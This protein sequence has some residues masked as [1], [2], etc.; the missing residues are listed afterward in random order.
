MIGSLGSRDLGRTVD[1]LSRAYPYPAFLFEAEGQLCWMSD[2]GMLRVGAV[3]TRAGG[4]PLFRD[5][6]AL[7]AL[8]RCARAIARDPSADVETTLRRQGTLRRCERVAIRHFGEHGTPLLLLAVTPVLAAVP[9][10]RRGGEAPPHGGL[11]AA[12]SR[13]ACLAA[14]GYTVL[15]ISARLG[16]SESTVRTH[17]RRVYAKLG[18]HGR[19]ELAGRM[20]RG[21]G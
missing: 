6:A 15:N 18:V 20:L 21:G 4:G 7:Q 5:N 14:E 12:E 13:V 17:L 2:E 1:A 9:G 11:G 19:A 8:S 3:A 10:E 16:V